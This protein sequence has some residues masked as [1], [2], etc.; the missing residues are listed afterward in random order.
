[1]FSL[2]PRSSSRIW[3]HVGDT[4]MGPIIRGHFMIRFLLLCLWIF[5]PAGFIRKGTVLMSWQVKCGC[6]QNSSGVAAFCWTTEAAE[7]WFKT[8]KQPKKHQILSL[9]TSDSLTLLSQQL[10]WRLHVHKGVNLVW[11]QLVMCSLLQTVITAAWTHLMIL[12]LFLFLTVKLQN[13]SVVYDTSPEV[14]K[15]TEIKWWS[16]K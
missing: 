6:P 16:K 8:K 9:C 4:D 11:D 7:T 14:F 3:G 13:C 10:Q 12:W 15:G 2:H 5:V 1:M